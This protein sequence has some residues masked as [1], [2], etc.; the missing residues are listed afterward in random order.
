MKMS[1]FKSGL[2]KR[3]SS[4]FDGVPV[5]GK[6]NPGGLIAQQTQ[7]DLQVSRSS[8][9]Q[10]DEQNQQQTSRNLYKDAPEKTNKLNVKVGKKGRNFAHD[11]LDKL[12]NKL[13]PS[14]PGV[15]R[16]RQ[17]GSIVL[18][19]ILCVVLVI[20]FV[21]VFGSGSPKKKV[22]KSGSSVIEKVGN[23]REVIWQVP[24]PVSEN[25]R[26]PMRT[27]SYSYSGSKDPSS[28]G[29]F[30][31]EG[32][33]ILMGIVHSTEKPLAIIG[34]QIVTEGEKIGDYTVVK[35]SEHAVEIE[36]NGQR[37]SIK[38]GQRWVVSE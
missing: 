24:K 38:V 10:N 37:K 21:K 28:S 13:L 1:P 4:I 17:I 26:D 3:I 22:I 34:H 29:L 2:H 9:K 7:P 18:I 27:N 25:M 12:K 32:E 16:T 33:I 14:K 6:D 23:S 5:N 11:L 31:P 15:S 36:K 30:G 8:S 19:P 35:I 20:V